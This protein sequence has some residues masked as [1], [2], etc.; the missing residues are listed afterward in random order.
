MKELNGHQKIIKGHILPP[1]M[2]HFMQEY[3]AQFLVI[4]LPQSA[5]RKQQTEPGQPEDGRA[6][7]FR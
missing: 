4:Q 6:A 1:H 7:Q 2:S 5:F 3:H